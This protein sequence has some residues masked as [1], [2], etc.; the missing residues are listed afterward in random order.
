MQHAD[1][2]L[3]YLIILNW[4]GWKDTVECVESCQR[5][6]YDGV[7]ILIVDNGSTDGSESFLR[8]RFPTVEFLQTDQ[9]LGFAGGNNAGIRYALERGADYVWLLN[10][11]T[12]AAPDSLSE[13][14]AVADM[15]ER[16]GIVGSKIC[17][18]DDPSKIW[19]AGGIWDKHRSFTSHRG[20][21]EVDTGQYDDISAVGFISG[22]SLLASSIMIKEIGM[23]KED[24]FLYWEDVDWSATAGER[25]WKVLIA[26]RSRVRHKVSSSTNDK[27]SLQSYY[28]MRSGL[29]FFQRHAPWK[30]APFF[31]RAVSYAISCY[32]RGQRDVLRGY[33]KGIKDYLLRRFGRA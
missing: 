32:R 2:K 15:D 25:G 16:T 33:L 8:K 24:Y 12:V 27:S 22:C 13:L 31:L 9:N 10:N 4:N 30:I 21:N 20:I 11:D 23:M 19:F 17:Y 6:A 1:T 28:F 14:V 18:Y 29:L 26:P 5:L 7:R 3:V